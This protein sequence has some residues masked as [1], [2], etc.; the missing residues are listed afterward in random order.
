MDFIRHVTWCV[1]GLFAGEAGWWIGGLGEKVDP[2]IPWWVGLVGGL[3]V[4]FWA[5]ERYDRAAPAKQEDHDA[6]N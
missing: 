2:N 4:V 3:I 6:G 1:A 5:G